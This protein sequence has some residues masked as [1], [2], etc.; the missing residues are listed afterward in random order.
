MPWIFASDKFETLKTKN[1]AL[2]FNK[3][4]ILITCTDAKFQKMDITPQP[5]GVLNMLLG[6]SA[7]GNAAAKEFLSELT[8]QVTALSEILVDQIGRD[9]TIEE[10][11]QKQTGGVTPSLGE[12][13]TLGRLVV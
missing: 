13:R 9:L 4:D 5:G 11:R 12:R 3:N 7:K 6:A 10:I 2:P 1:R 8:A